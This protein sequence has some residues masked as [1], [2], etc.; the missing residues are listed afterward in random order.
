MHG[1]SVG[2]SVACYLARR[3]LVDFCFIDRSFSAL[4][5]VAGSM[6]GQWAKIG[7]KLITNISAKDHESVEDYV[8]SNCYK[9]IAQDPNDELITELVSLKVGL[10]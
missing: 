9:V 8:Y 6:L 5:T 2:G 1:T 10:N 4:D 3:G 7:I